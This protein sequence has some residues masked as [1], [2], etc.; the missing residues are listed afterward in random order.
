MLD[1][2]YILLSTLWITGL[3]LELA[4]LSMAYD[5]AAVDKQP[6]RSVLSRPGCRLALDLGM[7]LFCGG[8]AGLSP[9]WWQ[10]LIWSLLGV[11]FLFFAAYHLR[12][13]R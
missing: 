8:L 11:G 1:W 12:M 10:L 13:A 4:V 2:P 5:N 9:T 6:F 7:L 3:S